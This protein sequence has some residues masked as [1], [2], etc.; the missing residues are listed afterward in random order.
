[1][2]PF[3]YLRPTRLQEVVDLLEE[4]GAAARV[5]AGGTDLVV[6]LHYAKSIPR[7]VIDI[8]RTRDLRAV[9][10]EADGWLTIS[11]TVPLSEVERHKTV[12]RYFPALAEAAAVVGSVQIR[13]RATLVG[14]VCNASPAADTVPVLAVHDA[15]VK[16][17]GRGGERSLPLVDFIQGNRH[18]SLAAG[19]VATAV[20]IRIPDKPYG[21]AF[22]RLTRRYGVDLA[23][24]NLCCGVD[25]AGVTTFAFGAVSPRPLVVRDD[26]GVLA[27]PSAA[28][29]AKSAVLDG[30][31]AKAAPITDVRATAAYRL[32]MLKVL[33]QRAQR[34]ANERFA[35]GG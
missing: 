11:A 24:V 27:N 5:L 30:L 6:D 1:M 10:T 35:D 16:V 13:N 2:L 34:R 21:S 29:H 14:N 15:A 25:R 28:A 19:E 23:I 20:S 22:A 12:R 7:V 9:I 4:H 17:L 3:R 32:A 33:A 31:I 18:T 26:D 8:K